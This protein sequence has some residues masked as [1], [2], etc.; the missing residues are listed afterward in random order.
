MDV[1]SSLTSALP[2]GA[3]ITDPDSMDAYRWDRANDPDAG[4]P[5]AVVRVRTTEEVQT[6]VRI[7]AEAKVPIVPRGAGSGL[8]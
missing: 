2:A 3:V 8:S 1:V 4:V 5:A 6:V 7:A